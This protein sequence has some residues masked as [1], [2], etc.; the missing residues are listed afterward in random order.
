MYRAA[1]RIGPVA[2]PDWTLGRWGSPAMLALALLAM[3][4]MAAGS[5]LQL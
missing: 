1:Q 4:L 3:A 2:V 5:L